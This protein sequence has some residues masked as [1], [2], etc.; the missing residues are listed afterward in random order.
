MHVITRAVYRED[1]EGYLDPKHPQHIWTVTAPR[2]AD[3]KVKPKQLTFGRFDEGNACGRRTARRFISPRCGRRTVLRTARRVSFTPF[4]PA[5]A[6]R[7]R[8]HDRS[9]HAIVPADALSLSPDGKQIAFVAS[10]TSRSIPTPSPICGSSIS[11]PNASRAILPRNSITMSVGVF[12]DNASPRAGGRNTPIW[13]ADGQSLIEGYAQR[14]KANLALF[15]ATV[16]GDD[17]VSS[18]GRSDVRQPGVVRFRATPDGSK[19]VYIV[20]TPTR[21]NDLF[22]FD[23]ATRR[24]RRNS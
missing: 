9:E 5:A 23:R 16:A 1:D 3:E 2:N 10:T 15:D 8:S 4:R 17:P 21:V 6:N 12:G 24:R 13:T 20:S 18:T 22:V 14:R 11:T 19:I 7:P